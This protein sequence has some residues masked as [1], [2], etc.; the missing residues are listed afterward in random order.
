MLLSGG[1]L[2]RSSS[3]RVNAPAA[4]QGNISPPRVTLL[5]KQEVKSK[6]KKQERKSKVSGVQRSVCPGIIIWLPQI[7]SGMGKIYFVW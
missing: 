2:L 7:Y 4:R 1:I 5:P 3:R 6:K